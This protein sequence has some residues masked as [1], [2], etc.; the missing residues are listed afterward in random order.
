MTVRANLRRYFA[1]NGKNRNSKKQVP[2]QQIAR[3]INS[4]ENLTNHCRIMPV[5]K[6]INNLVKGANFQKGIV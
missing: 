4:I 6:G 2:K 1:R 5:T 3:R